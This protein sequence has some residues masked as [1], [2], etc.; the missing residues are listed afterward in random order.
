MHVLPGWRATRLWTPEYFAKHV[1]SWYGVRSQPDWLF[2]PERDPVMPLSVLPAVADSPAVRYCARPPKVEAS[3]SELFAAARAGEIPI[4]FYGNLNNF[5]ENSPRILEDVDPSPF[6]LPDAITHDVNMWIGGGNVTTL[7]H[8]DT[9]ANFYVQLRGQKRVVLFPPRF[10]GAFHLYPAMHPLHKIG[11]V[12]Q[13]TPDTALFPD[14]LAAVEQAGIEVVL[15][16]GDVL[17]LPPF[18]FHRVQANG[19]S[20]SVNVWSQVCV[21]VRVCVRARALRIFWGVCGRSLCV[22]APRSCNGPALSTKLGAYAS[23]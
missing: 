5:R 17:Y 11:Q 22:V 7:T 21:C 13:D 16:R 23:R 18:W 6:L 1:K 3:T 9:Y 4:Y 10:H 12:L 20:L 14:Y 15:S 8:Y 2:P 19:F